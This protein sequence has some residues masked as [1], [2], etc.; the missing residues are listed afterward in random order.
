MLSLVALWE[1][2]S[3]FLSE[4][5]KLF[6]SF[7]LSYFV[8]FIGGSGGAVERQCMRLVGEF[9]GFPWGNFRICLIYS[10]RMIILGESLVYLTKSM[11]GL[12]SQT[13]LRW[14]SRG[15]AS[16]HFRVFQ[17]SLMQLRSPSGYGGGPHSVPLPGP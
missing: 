2:S 3:V 4:S 17:I 6:N 15:P 1:G 7:N 12:W 10:I 14:I 11:H 16:I 9:L 13:L 8:S 5:F